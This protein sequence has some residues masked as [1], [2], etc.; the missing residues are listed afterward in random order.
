MKNNL[1]LSPQLQNFKDILHNPFL[2]QDCALNPFFTRNVTMQGKFIIWMTWKEDSAEVI[3][4]WFCQTSQIKS[5]DSQFLSLSL[6]LIWFCQILLDQWIKY[7]SCL[8]SF[9]HDPYTLLLWYVQQQKFKHYI[10]AV[11]KCPK[12]QSWCSEKIC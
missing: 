2:S 7:M 10:H 4:N 8:W 5:S 3:S 9:H 12:H 6:F 11:Q 1:P